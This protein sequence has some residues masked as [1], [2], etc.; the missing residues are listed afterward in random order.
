MT[1]A[2]GPQRNPLPPRMLT[3]D[4]LAAFLAITPDEVKRMRVTGTGPE[5]VKLGR[6]VRY[7]PRDLYAWLEENR[8]G[9]PAE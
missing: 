6:R 4:D 5:Y 8:H 7:L 9:S 2:P 3:T 1:T